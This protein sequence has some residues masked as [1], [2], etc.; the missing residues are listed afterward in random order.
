M[1]IKIVELAKSLGFKVTESYIQK[2][3]TVITSSID[4][5]LISSSTIEEEV[6]TYPNVGVKVTKDETNNTITTV[7]TTLENT[8]YVIEYDAEHTEEDLKVVLEFVQYLEYLEKWDGKL[9]TVIT[10]SEGVE[11]IIPSL[12]NNTTEKP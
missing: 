2:I 11:I 6:T 4:N 1:A 12:E 7:T 5:S 3:E 8:K 9:P 10:G